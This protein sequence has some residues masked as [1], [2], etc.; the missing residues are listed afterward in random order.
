MS[1]KL[2]VSNISFNANEND[3]A[4]VFEPIGT[5]TESKIIYDRETSRSRGF[6]FVTFE[7]AEDA[8]AAVEQMN[9]VSFLGRE[10]KVAIAEERQRAPR[11]EGAGNYR[12]NRNST[13]NY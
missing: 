5:V 13:Y 2:Y 10:L 11:T 9:N 4:S 12:G 8:A 1:N 6:G 7:K 3:L